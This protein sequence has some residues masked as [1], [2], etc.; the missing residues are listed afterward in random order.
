MNKYTEQLCANIKPDIESYKIGP[1][2]FEEFLGKLTIMMG[3]KPQDIDCITISNDKKKLRISVALNKDSGVFCEEPGEQSLTLLGGATKDNQVSSAAAKVLKA[4]GFVYTSS[5]NER[6]V[7]MY[8]VTEHKKTT[9]I[10]LNP[11]ILVAILIDTNY[12]DNN[13]IVDAVDEVVK[14]RQHDK[15]KFKGKKRTITFAR[16]Q[17]T[18]DNTGY[19][20]EQV[21]RWQNGYTTVE[22]CDCDEEDDD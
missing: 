12:Y 8:R 4:L 21:N 2:V 6:D 13:F 20:P 1:E 10:E 18:Y 14:K 22:D 16:V 19:N 11:E 17:C 5:E 3:G 7:Y 15:N 9:E